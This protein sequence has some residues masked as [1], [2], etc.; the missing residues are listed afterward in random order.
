MLRVELLGGLHKVSVPINSTLQ[1]ALLPP[2]DD[3]EPEKTLGREWERKF[4]SVTDVLEMRILPPVSEC[5]CVCTCVHHIVCMYACLFALRLA[6]QAFKVLEDCVDHKQRRVPGGVVL[7]NITPITMR[8]LHK[9]RGIRGISSNQIAH[10]FLEGQNICFS[11][12]QED[13]RSIPAAFIDSINFPQKARV[14]YSDVCTDDPQQNRWMQRM[15]HM[16]VCVFTARSEDDFLVV[17]TNVQE[18]HNLP[19][20][21]VSVPLTD[22]YMVRAWE[23]H[24]H[25]WA[26]T[27]ML[28]AV[29]MAKSGMLRSLFSYFGPLVVH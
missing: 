7:Y 28:C 25:E 21:V 14:F 26:Q 3:G 11:S 18:G 24:S 5:V 9:R 17:N 1:F 6:V 27:S 19:E 8:G 15:N 10:K 16:S 2:E 13:T 23:C 12:R 20:N 4:T 22:K 29:S